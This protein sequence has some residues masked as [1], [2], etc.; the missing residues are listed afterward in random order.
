MDGT[1]WVCLQK[2]AKTSPASFWDLVV[3]HACA[4]PERTDRR[5]DRRAAVQAE[6]GP[7]YLLQRTFQWFLPWA[8]PF[9]RTYLTL[10]LCQTMHYVVAGQDP[11]FPFSAFPYKPV[12]YQL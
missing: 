6:M 1:R 12:T 5:H 3:A 9:A 4:F 8:L 2:K 10:P 7:F 11:R